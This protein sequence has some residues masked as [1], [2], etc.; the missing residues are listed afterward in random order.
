MDNIKNNKQLSY[1]QG[2]FGDD[3]IQRNADTKFFQKRKPF[4]AALLRKHKDIKSILEIGCNIGGNLQ[5]LQEINPKLHLTAIEPNE[6]AA[7]TAQKNV[8]TSKIINTDASKITFEN[9]F[10][11]VFTAGV[12]I[13]IGDDN[14]DQTLRNM[15]KASSRYILTIEYYSSTRTSIPYRGLDD[16]LFKRPFDKEWLRLFPD[17]KMLETGFV[18][19]DKGFDDCHWWL[20]KK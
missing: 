10:N 16:A 6:Q 13:H 3:Y 5:V 7:K 19:T 12:L 14:L 1:W 18:G 17:L 4:F 11:L 20:F 15:H 8:P 9:V 2:K